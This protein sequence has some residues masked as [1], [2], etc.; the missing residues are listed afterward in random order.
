M[1]YF[2]CKAFNPIDTN[3]VTKNLYQIG[4]K[5]PRLSVLLDQFLMIAKEYSF[6]TLRNKEQLAYSVRCDSDE[7]HGVLHFYI[8]ILSQ[9]SKFTSEYIDDRIENFLNEF[10]TILTN[11]PD[12][13]FL[14]Y[15]KS[16]EKALM[17]DDNRLEI[18]L[19]RN[20]TE[21]Q[22]NRHRFDKNVKALEILRT[23][24]KN[25]VIEFYHNHFGENKRKL[26]IQVI[27]NG[28]T[29]DQSSDQPKNNPTFDKFTTLDF[30][31]THAGQLITDI[32]EF[33]HSLETHP[34]LQYF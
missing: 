10:L 17:I 33:R 25:D 15:K 5:T 1:S 7:I 2:R 4:V 31:T 28:E 11:M 18:E 24:T 20:W 14:V 8:Q 26:S 9:E 22:T 23:V 29:T 27:G 3:T 34:P 32:N 6:D 19:A 30:K 16:Q 13:E 12:E 21:I